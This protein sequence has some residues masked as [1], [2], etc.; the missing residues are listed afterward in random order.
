MRRIVILAAL[1]S[2]AACGPPLEWTRPNMSLA[3]ARMDYAECQGLA[4]D[5][6]FRESFY[7]SAFAGS[8]FGPGYPWSP[9]GRSYSPFYYDSFMSRAQ[10]ENDLQSF[11]MRAR[12]YRLT[13]VTQ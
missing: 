9:Y 4:R 1:A 7:G 5:E 3:E 6:A 12:G 10:R 8:R 13:P 11:C 2:L